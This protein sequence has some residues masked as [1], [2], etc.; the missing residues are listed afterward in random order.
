MENLS[1][2]QVNP[3]NKEERK[4]INDEE[5]INEQEEGLAEMQESLKEY[6]RLTEETIKEMQDGA[7]EM[8]EHNKLIKEL[9]Q[10]PKGKPTEIQN[11]PKEDKEIIEELEQKCKQLTEELKEKDKMIYHFKLLNKRCEMNKTDLQFDILSNIL[12]ISG[13]SDTY[14]LS[15]IGEKVFEI[16]NKKKDSELSMSG[17]IED[18]NTILERFI[19]AKFFIDYPVF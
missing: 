16:H 8:K 4:M 10:E 7:E 19:R 2:N 12:L 15:R 18:I 11:T 5:F 6:N 9:E 13:L 3:N 1:N 14:E 17:D